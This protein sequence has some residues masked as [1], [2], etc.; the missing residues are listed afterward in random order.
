MSTDACG[1]NLFR[2]NSEGVDNTV[3]PIERSRTTRTRST[4]CQSHFAGASGCADSSPRTLYIRSSRNCGE[5]STISLRLFKEAIQ[6]RHSKGL[7]NSVLFSIICAGFYPVLY[8]RFVNQHHWNIV[9]YWVNAP[10]F[11]AFQGVA[12]GF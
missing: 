5:D 12:I 3:S 10:A 11:D 1:R 2:A 7:F 6:T 4:I 9:A 8:L